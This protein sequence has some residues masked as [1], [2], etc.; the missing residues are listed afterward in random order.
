MKSLEKKVKKSEKVR[1]KYRKLHQKNKKNK[2]KNNTRRARI[3]FSLRVQRERKRVG[4]E[5]KGQPKGR[6]KTEKRRKR[7]N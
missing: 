1:Y 4:K 6:G 2:K 5:T 3:T 7:E